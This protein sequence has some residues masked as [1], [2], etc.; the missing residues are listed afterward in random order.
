MLISSLATAGE[1]VSASEETKFYDDVACLRADAGEASPREKRYV[2]ID[3][4]GWS[5]VEDAWFARVAGVS[6]PM[7]S[8]LVAFAT[9]EEAARRGGGIA[10]RWDDLKPDTGE[11]Q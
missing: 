9:R 7:G 8:G 3:G 6:T 4:G 2:Q 5:T 1:R 10:L 11:G